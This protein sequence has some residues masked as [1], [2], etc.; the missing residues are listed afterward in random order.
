ME[1]PL[2]GAVCLRRPSSRSV[3][4]PIKRC[5]GAVRRYSAL[6]RSAQVFTWLQLHI[7]SRIWPLDR[8]STGAAVRALGWSCRMAARPCRSAVE[9]DLI[10]PPG[11][12]GLQGVDA[13]PDRRRCR[14]APRWRGGPP[15]GRRRRLGGSYGQPWSR[16]TVCRARGHIWA[17]RRAFQRAAASLAALA[18]FAGRSDAAWHLPLP[19]ELQ[20]LDLQPIDLLLGV[21]ARHP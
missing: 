19:L 12:R 6:P 3:K 9:R 7:T 14:R 20:A 15:R 4:H 2:S 13:G 21:L 16:G 11:G 8:L 10:R 18:A 5:R 1:V 17:D